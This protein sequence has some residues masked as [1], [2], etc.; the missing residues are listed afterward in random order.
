MN[1]VDTKKF[2]TLHEVAER[3]GYSYIYVQTLWPSWEKFGVKA[4]R[5]G[6]RLLFKTE[7]IDRMVEMHA[8]N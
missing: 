6:R 4:Y 2:L 7:D 1:T 5:M 8:I 3:I